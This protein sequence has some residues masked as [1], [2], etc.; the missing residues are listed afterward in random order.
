MY[1][2]IK[3]FVL[4][5]ATIFFWGSGY[6]QAAEISPEL[7][8]FFDN[9]QKFYEVKI[10]LNTEGE[11]INAIEGEM[12]YQESNFDFQKITDGSSIV[13]FWLKSPQKSSD[14]KIIFSG[15]MPGR[16]NGEKGF[17]FSTVFLLRSGS[18]VSQ[19]EISFQNLKV[20]LNDSKGTEKKLDDFQS[21]LDINDVMVVVAPVDTKPPEV[22]AP[23]VT[24]DPNLAGG[25]WVVILK[26]QDKGEGIDYY[27]VF[28]STEK[29]E[30]EEVINNKSLP[31]R[32]VEDSNAFMLNDQSLESYVYAKAVDKAGNE[33]MAVVIPA[34]KKSGHFNYKVFSVIIILSIVVSVIFL[35]LFFFRKRKYG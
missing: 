22:F 4:L 2:N 27:E 26:A 13:N 24:R 11:S 17:L 15:G 3:I 33:R 32:V 8:S 29:Y 30:L 7:S 21:A 23:Y 5:L 9:G 19:T 12:D 10:F 31:W 1:R 34:V 6:A 14:G 20:Y 35:E 28:E 25:R 16:Y 18:S